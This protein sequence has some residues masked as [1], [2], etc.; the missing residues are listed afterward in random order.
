MSVLLVPVAGVG[1]RYYWVGE[2]VAKQVQGLVASFS[3]WSYGA[4]NYKKGAAG[5]FKPAFF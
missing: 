4:A 3:F 2:K 1:E 5:F